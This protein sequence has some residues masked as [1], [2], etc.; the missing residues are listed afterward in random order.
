MDALS[1]IEPTTEAEWAAYFDLRWRVLRKPW[2]Q[3]R[4]SERDELDPA[5][6]HVMI[7]APDGTTVAV[8]RL[9]LNS[10]EEA[11]VRYMAVDDSWQDQGLGGQI[12]TGLERHARAI[13][14]KR[15][16]LNARDKA[17]RFYERHGYRVI[18]P[19][20]TL[21]EDVRHFK[22]LKELGDGPPSARLS[23]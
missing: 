1:I 19:A 17:Q 4:G 3:P 12:L 15:I 9:H 11:Q 21:F 10:P 16:V 5:A 7:Q 14:V 18:G 22:M 2:D 6:Y 20:P 8:G 23:A 13:S